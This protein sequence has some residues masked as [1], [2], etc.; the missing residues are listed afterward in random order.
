ML[1]VGFGLGAFLFT[2]LTFH[3]PTTGFLGLIIL[4]GASLSTTIFFPPAYLV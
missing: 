3:S 1:T 2:P 4:G